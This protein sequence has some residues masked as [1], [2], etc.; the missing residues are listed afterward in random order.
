M[1]FGGRLMLWIMDLWEATF[2][3]KW[4][5]DNPKELWGSLWA[6]MSY[7]G[8]GSR[9]DRIYQFNKQSDMVY[10]QG[11]ALRNEIFGIFLE[12]NHLP[13]VADQKKYVRKR[14]LKYVGLVHSFGSWSLSEFLKISVSLG[15]MCPK[16]PRTLLAI[17][18]CIFCF[19]FLSGKA[20]SEDIRV[21][22][23]HC[24]PSVGASEIEHLGNRNLAIHVISKRKHLYWICT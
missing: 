20:E 6:T 18:R 12:S 17:L 9:G 11:A 16:F 7:E 19:F 4:R 8:D 1:P 5:L 15:W 2:G 24:L 23:C 10:L 3:E 22:E 14:R 13:C 21:R